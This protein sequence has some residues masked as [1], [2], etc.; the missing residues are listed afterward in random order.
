MLVEAQPDPFTVDAV[1]SADS[2]IVFLKVPGAIGEGD[3]VQLSVTNVGSSVDYSGASVGDCVSNPLGG[4][5]GVG[6]QTSGDAVVFKVPLPPTDLV[7]VLVEHRI[8]ES[9]GEI[10]YTL[11][12]FGGPREPISLGAFPQ[13]EPG[14]TVNTDTLDD[15]FAE[16]LDLEF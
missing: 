1:R 10:S 15:V 2:L 8:F 7:D 4:E 5:A 13:V 16:G 12:T 11:S 9:P 14:D 6:T 3:W